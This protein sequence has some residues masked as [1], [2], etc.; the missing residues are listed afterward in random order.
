V[1]AWRETHPQGTAEELVG[2]L[3][4]GFHRDYGIVLRGVLFAVDRQRARQVTGITVIDPE[5]PR[6]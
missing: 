5:R 1:A 2:E 4:V 6:S 3:G